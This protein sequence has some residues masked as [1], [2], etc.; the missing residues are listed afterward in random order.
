MDESVAS[1]MDSLKASTMDKGEKDTDPYGGDAERYVLESGYSLMLA[2][3]TEHDGEV[4]QYTVLMPGLNDV[5]LRKM[6]PKSEP[7]ENHY[8]LL[9]PI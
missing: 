2:E 5:I 6:T 4:I 8:L 1:V 7:N 9:G 3:K